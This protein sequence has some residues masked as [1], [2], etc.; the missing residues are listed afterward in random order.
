MKQRQSNESK[1]LGRTE[2]AWLG[3]QG[4]A[5]ATGVDGGLEV[6]GKVPVEHSR[7]R[8]LLKQREHPRVQFL[9]TCC[10]QGASARGIARRALRARTESNAFDDAQKVDARPQRLHGALLSVTTRLSHGTHP[11]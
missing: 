11:H 3:Q 8:V 9:V 10:Q 5:A 7:G 4:D 6:R 2:W 1:K